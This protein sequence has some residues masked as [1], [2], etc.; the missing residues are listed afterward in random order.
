[1][2]SYGYTDL[3]RD[4]LSFDVENTFP[5]GFHAHEHGLFCKEKGLFT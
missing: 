3:V 2:V 4:L 1:M 5:S